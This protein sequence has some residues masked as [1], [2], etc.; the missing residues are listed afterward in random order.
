MVYLIFHISVLQNSGEADSHSSSQNNYRI[1]WNL[2][3][4]YH[5]Y[6]QERAIR[7][8]LEPDE[9]SAHPHNIFH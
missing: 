1:S 2:E 4:H 5:V 3:V 7:P 8:Y 6:L 9:S